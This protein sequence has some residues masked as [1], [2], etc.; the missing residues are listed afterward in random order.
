MTLLL[1]EA[2]D[3]VLVQPTVRLAAMFMRD[4]Q[5]VS[6]NVVECYSFFGRVRTNEEKTDT[7]YK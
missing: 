6:L 7:P 2:D 4:P 5:R 3:C 1:A